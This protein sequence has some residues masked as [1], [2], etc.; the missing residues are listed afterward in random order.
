MLWLTLHSN[1]LIGT[2]ISFK[3]DAINFNK[4]EYNDRRRLAST[5]TKRSDLKIQVSYP[6]MAHMY[7]KA[8]KEIILTHL[9]A[10]HLS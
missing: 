4:V 1:Y 6:L 5:E 3:K 7:S 8:S 9:A 2:N 10:K